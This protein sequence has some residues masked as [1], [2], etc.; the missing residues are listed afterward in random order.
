[1]I[2]IV[3]I[4]DEP[5]VRAS[6]QSFLDW[7]SFGFSFIGEASDGVEGL[8]LLTRL[9]HVDL[10]LL[11]MQMPKMSGI[12][13][14]QELLKVDQPPKVI[15]LSANDNYNYVRESFRLGAIDY[16][17]KMN[18]DEKNLLG[19]LQKTASSLELNTRLV[20]NN[21]D[22][23][24][25]AH[26]L[27]LD[28]L[29]NRNIDITNT[30]LQDIGINI[31]SPIRILYMWVNNFEISDDGNNDLDLI[32]IQARQYLQKRAT[33]YI[34]PI[35]KGEWIFIIN[36][37]KNNT[38]DS[39]SESFCNDFTGIIEN[40]LDFSINYGFSPIC[41]KLDKL[42]DY[43][44]YVKSL[45]NPETRMVRKAKKY[46]RE[47]FA[48][49][50]L[51]LDEVSDYVEISKTHLSAQFKKETRM[52][53]RNYLTKVRVEEAKKLLQTTNLKVYEISEKIGY[54]NVEHFSRI[55]KKET[56]MT[57]NRFASVI[58]N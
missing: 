17:L 6:I 7:K 5:L 39:F 19:I 40:S 48:N 33:G 36:I 37:N 58:E 52:T 2:N 43:Y 54:P 20:V 30:L 3:I 42:P 50:N 1:M 44:K 23:E 8:E 12:E 14:L 53:F 11:D 32:T 46:I 18:I 47:N 31:Q 24:Y 25:M 26:K 29:D 28:L 45:H 10:I 4:D 21:K 15:V 56:N 38:S 16:I 49:S 41:E 55:F 13:F 35:K 34:T 22:I 51:S 9:E 57:P 27:I